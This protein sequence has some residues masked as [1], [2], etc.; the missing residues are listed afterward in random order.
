MSTELLDLPRSVRKPAYLL[1]LHVSAHASSIGPDRWGL[2]YSGRSYLRV[3]V[4][5][6]EIL[7]LTSDGLRLILD[8]EMAKEQCPRI[9]LHLGNN[10]K[11]FYPTVP[12]SALIECKLTPSA[13]LWD[14]LPQLL[15]AID[16]SVEFAAR[17][18]VSRTVRAGHCEWAY[19][20][21]QEAVGGGDLASGLTNS[22]S[23]EPKTANAG[24]ALMEGALR[25]VV[26]SRPERRRELRQACVEHFG[27]T[28]AVCDF[29]FEESYG[30]IGRNFIHVHHLTPLGS[31]GRVSPDPTRDLRPVC[32]NCH[33]MLHRCDP[34]LAIEELR[35]LHETQRQ[36]G[37]ARR[38]RP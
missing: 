4:G 8:R 36:L 2:T 13:F 18:R 22:R 20:K 5:W 6:T 10:P 17:R 19:R 37:E 29:S 26:S 21:L 31:V 24:L 11:G 3:N 27:F 25:R 12:G 35:D 1:A 32:P 23:T 28:C 30:P 16:R 33:A 34:P 9:R 7:T 14:H 15:P 38:R